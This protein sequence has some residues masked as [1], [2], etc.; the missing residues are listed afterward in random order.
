VPQPNH[1]PAFF[2]ETSMGALRRAIAAFGVCVALLPCWVSVPLAFAQLQQDVIL[3]GSAESLPTEQPAEPEAATS[4]PRGE[5]VAQQRL[6]WPDLAS[7]VSRESPTVLI[8]DAQRRQSEFRL[9]EAQLASLPSL[10]M[11][12]GVAPTPQVSVDLDENGNPIQGTANETD[13]ELATRIAGV[14][15]QGSLEINLPIYTFGKLSLARQL[16]SVGVDVDEVEFEKAVLDALFESYRAFVGLQWYAEVDDL[17]SEAEARL[18]DAALRLDD[19][20]FDG[21]TEARGALRQLTIGRT[22]FISLRSNADRVGALARFALARGLGLEEDFRTTRFDESIPTHEPPD[23]DEVLQFARETRPDYAILDAAV[24]AADLRVR[25]ERRAF[26][27]DFGFIVNVGGSFAPTIENLRGPYVF[28]PYNRF[29]VGFSLGFRW[30]INPFT[31][32]ASLARFSAQSQEA[33][34]S[35]DAAWLGIEVEVTEAWLEACSAREVV[36]AYVEALD[37]A[38]AWLNQTAFQ[39]DQGLIDFEEF[40]GPMTTYYETAGGY[41]KALLDYRLAVA[42]LA[43]K[44]GSRELTQWPG[45]AAE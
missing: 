43:V 24:T 5:A 16:A 25:L 26:A 27:P 17:L 42:N 39:W 28:D 1:V 38:D 9:L 15:M 12:L 31:R 29:S 13:L 37:A 7:R 30:N 11:R 2:R 36:L 3:A 22:Q 44:T 18:D 40:Q 23:R 14:G 4:E 6:S 21:D 8:A 32:G 33:V 34:L 19:L 45:E 20:I 35:R 10:S 41:F